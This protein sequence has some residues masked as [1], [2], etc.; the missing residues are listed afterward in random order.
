MPQ[1]IF[2][3]RELTQ[4]LLMQCEEEFDYY[5]FI[6]RINHEK[7]D[8]A[9]I[10]CSTP[11]IDID[12]WMAKKISNFCK[13]ALAGPHLTDE[14]V[15][16]IQKEYPEISFFLKGEY[17]YSSYKMIQKM[18]PG[19]FDAEVVSDLDSIPFPFRDYLSSTFYFDPTILH[20]DHS[21]RFMEV[22]VSFKCSYCMWPQV[23]YNGK[24][25]LR[26]QRKSQKK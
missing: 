22:R 26:D 18:E 7:P 1:V 20:P 12:L 9:V 4:Q 10:E 11:T 6:Q 23:M 17:I 8:I 13:V 19:I 5:K 25:A 16:D 24:V 2:V 21:C 3:R 15:H 14:N